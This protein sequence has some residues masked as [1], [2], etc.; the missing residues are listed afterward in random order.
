[1]YNAAALV[2]AA[3]VGLTLVVAPTIVSARIKDSVSVTYCKSGAHV[4]DAK[5]CKE[6]GGTR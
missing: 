5:L 2:L 3:V 1:M 4:K 6:N